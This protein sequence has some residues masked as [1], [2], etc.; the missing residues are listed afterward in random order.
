MFSIRVDAIPTIR[1][2]ANAETM[3]RMN[4]PIRGCGNIPLSNAE[5]MRKNHTRYRMYRM[6]DNG[7]GFVYHKTTILKVY[8]YGEDTIYVIDVDG[9]HTRTTAQVLDRLLPL[10]QGVSRG[11]ING[12]ASVFKDTIVIGVAGLWYPVPNEGLRVIK[13]AD[14][15]FKVLNPTPQYVHSINRTRATEVR[16]QYRE[17]LAYARGI[18]KVKVQDGYVRFHEHEWRYPEMGAWQQG[19]AEYTETPR[20]VREVMRGSDT[21]AFYPAL[22]AVLYHEGPGIRRA[23]SHASCMTMINRFIMRSHAG[24]VLDREELPLGVLKE[25][26][27]KQW[28]QLAEQAARE[29]VTP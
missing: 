8:P 4:T 19:V 14:G 26:K 23:M 2:F 5:S 20:R 10:Y 15:T 7:I 9:W 25:D 27:Y 6:A 29:G 22:L 16:K 1:S 18:L 13:K 12:G 21:E 28:V 3:L 24:E 11:V 17:F